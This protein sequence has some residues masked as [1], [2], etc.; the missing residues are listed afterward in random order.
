MKAILKRGMS[1]ISAAA[2]AVSVSAAFP[3]TASADSINPETIEFLQGMGAGWILGNT[4]DGTG[5]G[6]AA[7]TSWQKDKTTKELIEAVH[8]AGFETIRIPVTWG[9]HMS[10]DYV[11]DQAWLDR[12]HEV[13]DWAYNDG[14]HVV[15]NIHHDNLAKNT[16]SSKFGFYPDSGHK[17]GSIKFVTGV[18]KTLAEEFKDYDEKLVFETLNEPRLCGTNYEWWFD[19]SN[20]DVVVKDTIATIDEMN[21]AAVDVIR[22]SGGNNAT[23]YIICPGYSAS[24]NGATLG[25]LPTDIA[26]NDDK[27]LRSIH[28]YDPND[29]CLG[30]ETDHTSAKSTSFSDS[31]KRSLQTSFNTYKSFVD[32]GIPVV[33]DE[34]GISDKQ[35]N[36]ARTQWAAEAFRLS[37]E[38]DLPCFLWDNNAEFSSTA[39]KGWNEHHRHANRKTGEWVDPDVINA[40]MDAMGVTERTIIADPT[41]SAKKSQTISGV[42]SSYTKY[43]GD[44]AFTLSAR[45]SG[46]GVISYESSNTS[47]VT[48]ANTGKVTVKGIGQATITVRATETAEYAPAEKKITVTVKEKSVTPTIDAIADQD[49]T[50]KAITPDVKVRIPG[51]VLSKGYYDVTYSDNVNPGTAAVKVTLKNG[52]KGTATANFKIV[53]EVPAPKKPAKSSITTVKVSSNCVKLTW[54]KAANATGYK[55]YRYDNAKKKWV[56]AATTD[57]KTLTFSDKGRSSATVYKYRI[58][59]FSK[60]GGKTAWGDYSSTKSALTKPKTLTI[61]KVN[62]GKTAIKLTWKKVSCTGY[63]VQKYDTSKKKWTTV[64]TIK[65]SKTVSYKITGLKKNKTYKLRVRAYKKSGSLKSNSNWTTKSVKTAK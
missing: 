7:E 38:Y 17:E 25:T 30:S 58:R 6:L 11:I 8:D 50:G 24:I 3:V 40:I 14:M 39:A 32:Q 10:G 19:A 57:A 45:T 21:Q 46:K 53:G 64:K 42:D 16:A 49:Y 35:N 44:A 34:M 62:K 2:I 36:T 56:T 37:N 63:Q 47:V 61:T 29:L 13:V 27:I 59:A 31:A 60:A 23:R 43:F 26:G 4:F 65:S 28:C 15:I 18:W 54:K 41:V 9:G 33:I 5:S 20:P 22:Q 55:V 52:Y 12:V 1:A 48:V 51:K